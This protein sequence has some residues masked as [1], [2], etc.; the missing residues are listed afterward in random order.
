M[1]FATP[2]IAPDLRELLD[3]LD[4]LRG[5]LGQEESRS[6]RWMGSLRRQVRATSVE[7]STSIEG[8]HVSP[9]E[10]VALVS[11]DEAVDPDDENQMA[12]A[13]Y[14]R[15]MDHVGVMATDPAFRW[16][17]RVILDLHFDACYFQ[18]DRSP[19]LW[20]TGPIGVTEANGGLLYE[21]PAG[22]AV[23]RLMAE[24]VD[25]LETGDLDAHVVVRAAMA[26]LHVVS[27]HPFR[28]GNGRISRIVQ[29][30]VLAREG[31]LSPEFASIEEYLGERTPAY[32]RALQDA[33]GG[34]YRPD[35]DASGWVAFCVEAHLAQARK[36]LAQIEAAAARW[37]YLEDLVE[38]RGWPDRF[39][40][41]LEQ[42]LIGGS[43]RTSYGEEAEVSPATASADLRR[44][45]DAGLVEQRGRGRNTRYD[46]SESL[47]FDLVA[48]RADRDAG[49]GP[50]P[51]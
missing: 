30:L 49:T 39:V 13:C 7:S 40:I 21:G 24:V 2:P 43:D 50:A 47:R 12:V 11:G 14:A 46:A 29:S 31:L 44:L 3:E 19:G 34:R 4:E 51:S 18:R 38:R 5:A 26:H 28:D 37:T 9:A 8:Y 15:A 42:S 41:A 35:R 1:L 22:D 48:E 45:L 25:W 16:L 32:Y 10:A 33:Q 27:V 20:R 6:V 17:D 23:P 36:R